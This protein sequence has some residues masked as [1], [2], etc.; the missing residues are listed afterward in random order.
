VLTVITTILAGIMW[1]APPD[2]QPPEPRLATPLDYLLYIPLS[3]YYSIVELWKHTLLHPALIGEGVTFS[4]CLLAILFSHEMGHYLACRHYKVDATLP[5]FIPAP[6]IFLA[7]TF[8]AFI[9]IRAAIPTRRA[10]FD[11]GL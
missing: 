6:P 8:G 4:V 7:G 2:L 10:L 11:I 1:G 9:K 5:Y 3:Y